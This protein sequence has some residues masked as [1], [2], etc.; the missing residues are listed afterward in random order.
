MI[1]TNSHS[2]KDSIADNKHTFASNNFIL[3]ILTS[4]LIK[5][6]YSLMFAVLRNL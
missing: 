4:Y 5:V 3:G 1:I 2:L 6:I